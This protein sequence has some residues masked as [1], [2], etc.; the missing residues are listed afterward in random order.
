MESGNDNEQFA[1]DYNSGAVTVTDGLDYEAKQHHQLVVRATDAVGG[2]YAE[3]IVLLDIQARLFWNWAGF[4]K[5]RVSSIS[6]SLILSV[7]CQPR[8]LSD[9]T[10]SA[11]C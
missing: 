7:P 1:V 3:T 10:R 11:L 5:S 2:G 8:T 6:C 9:L 4:S